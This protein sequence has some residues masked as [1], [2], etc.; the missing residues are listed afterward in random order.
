MPRLAPGD[1]RRWLGV[2][3]DQGGDHHGGHRQRRARRGEPLAPAPPP[4]GRAD[5]LIQ[6]RQAQRRGAAYWHR[7]RGGPGGGAEPLFGSHHGTRH[8]PAS[9]I[10]P[11][12]RGQPARGG[13]FDRAGADPHG[14]RDLRFGLVEVE[15]EHQGLPLPVRQPPQGA[16][17]LPVLLTEERGLFG[18]GGVRHVR[19]RAAAPLGP[20]PLPQLRA[21]PVECGGAGVAERLAG[22]S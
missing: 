7:A 10:S 18:R 22:V 2:A 15:P 17:D 6:V 21:A 3:E 5:G 20:D 19:R 12:Q 1:R 13:G 8:R 16:E 14:L 4:A 11:A 9:W